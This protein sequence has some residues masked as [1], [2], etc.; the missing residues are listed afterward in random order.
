MCCI[1]LTLVLLMCS[2]SICMYCLHIYTQYLLGSIYVTSDPGRTLDGYIIHAWR[3]CVLQNKS[4]TSRS[5][6]GVGWPPFV[7]ELVL[8]LDPVETG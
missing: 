5:H 3:K 7:E 2:S 1:I 6:L 4:V 8:R